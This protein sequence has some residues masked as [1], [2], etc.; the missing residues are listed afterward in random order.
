MFT[1]PRDVETGIG[2]WCRGGVI[3]KGV[4]VWLRVVNV[5]AYHLCDSNPRV[6]SLYT[7]CET[8]IRRQ[9]INNIPSNHF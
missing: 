1:L 6:Y 7:K 4:V 8:K 2:G 5:L 9:G 3:H